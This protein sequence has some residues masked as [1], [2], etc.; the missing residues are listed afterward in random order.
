MTLRAA[1]ARL[2]D[3]PLQV[4]SASRFYETPCFPVD[5]GPD[6]INSAAVLSGSGNPDEI[7]EI[8]HRVEAEFGRERD[9]RWGQRTLDLDLIAVG[10]IVLPDREVFV[11]WR[12]LPLEQQIS[13]AP[14]QLILP[15][16]RMQDRAFVLVPLAEIVP[17]WCHPVS[18]LTVTEMLAN[19]PEDEKSLVNP[20]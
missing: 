13:A 15:H 20:V 14:Q 18:G 8:L 19:L 12:N 1:L 6:Y 9:T 2:D 11:T 5:A 3:S 7:L 17:D 16:P 4:E 10:E